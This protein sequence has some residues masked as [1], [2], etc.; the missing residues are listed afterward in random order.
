MERLQKQT[1]SP[2]DS[3]REDLGNEPG[4]FTKQRKRK[5]VKLFLV[6]FFL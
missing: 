1:C 3:A 2:R 6:S 4:R 5:L